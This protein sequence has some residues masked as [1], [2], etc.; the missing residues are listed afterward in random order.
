MSRIEKIAHFILPFI[1]LVVAVCTIYCFNASDNENT[2]INFEKPASWTDGW[3]LNGEEEISLPYA[4]HG[5]RNEEFMITNILPD[6][7]SNNDAIDISSNYCYTEIIIGGESRYSYGSKQVLPFGHMIGNIKCIVPL[8]EE[9]SGKDIQIRI[10][11]YYTQGYQIPIVKLGTYRGICARV[12]YDNLW[13]ILICSILGVFVIISIF[14]GVYQYINHVNY[15]RRLIIYFSMFAM[16]AVTW[17]ICSSDIPQLFT[18]ANEAVSF[19]SY[20]SL[21]FIGAPFVAFCSE[22]FQTGKNHFI[23]LAVVG[24]INTF[25]VM[26]CFFTGIADPPEI[27]ISSHIYFVM[28]VISDVFFSI[29]ER[30]QK[31]FTYKCMIIANICLLVFVTIGLI[32]FYLNPTSGHDSVFFS[33]GFSLFIIIMF[34]ILVRMQVDVT[35]EKVE[36]EVYKELAYMDN[37]TKIGNR[38]AFDLEFERLANGEYS[39]KSSGTLFVFDL[40][41][42]K[43]VND[44]KGHRS[45]DEIIIGASRCIK[46]TFSEIGSIFRMGGDEFSVIVLQEI[47]CDEILADLDARIEKC[48]SSENQTISIA[49]GYESFVP[50]ELN[51]EKMREVFQK[52]DDMMYRNKQEMKS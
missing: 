36:M 9:D 15:G 19:L 48:N 20:M 51:I 1:M 18:D 26:L 40:N 6:A 44:M 25:V 16:A 7:L 31:T 41:N 35:K 22:V 33:I 28:L 50:S 11:P 27:L 49:R 24:C 10:V 32:A 52:A 8:T 46:E 13:K 29:K 12:L 23:S 17:I 34:Y 47:N 37:M 45:G 42:L 21:A 4:I 43:S 5:I 2:Q 38:A 14:F 3:I 39:E 30:K